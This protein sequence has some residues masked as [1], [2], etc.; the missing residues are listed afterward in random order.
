[1]TGDLGFALTNFRHPEVLGAR[2]R[3]SKD[4]GP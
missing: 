3:A 1:L 4:D 2:R